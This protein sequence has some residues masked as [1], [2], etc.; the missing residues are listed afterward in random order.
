M[1]SLGTVTSVLKTVEISVVVVNRMLLTGLDN[2]TTMVETV[3][4]T[5][6]N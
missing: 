6:T 3:I 5:E 2:S 4:L 1:A